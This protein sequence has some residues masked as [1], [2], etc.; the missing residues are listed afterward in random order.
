MHPLLEKLNALPHR[1]NGSQ[2]QSQTVAILREELENAG[3][4]VSLQDFESPKTYATIV[5][6]GFFVFSLLLILAPVFRYIDLV[7]LLIWTVWMYNHANGKATPFLKLPPLVKSQNVVGRVGAS[8]AAVKIILMAHHDSAPASVLNTKI[9]QLL[10]PG[11]LLLAGIAVATAVNEVLFPNQDYLFWIKHALILCFFLL[12]VV[13][14]YGYFR[15]GFANNQAT[16]VAAAFESF[17]LLKA[18]NLA[19]V[20][21][22]IVLTG[23]AAVGGVGAHYYCEVNRNQMLKQPTLLVNFDDLA[24][25]DLKIIAQT[26]MVEKQNYDNLVVNAAKEVVANNLRFKNVRLANWYSPWFDS[27]WF[28]QLGIPS[29]TLVAGQGEPKLGELAQK[30]S[31]QQA[32]ELAFE[33]LLLSVANIKI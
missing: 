12:A 4:T 9:N 13:S 33:T 21:I 30:T 15:H 14:T 2:Y 18:K 16:G 27:V 26:G 7:F 10:V 29:M 6:W 32:A 20:E 31:V 17:R 1:G 25:E 11:S 23:A 22:E 8:G 3:A 28:Q 5:W 19:N 24:A